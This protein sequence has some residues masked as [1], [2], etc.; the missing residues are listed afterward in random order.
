MKNMHTRTIVITHFDGDLPMFT[1]D[2]A[3]QEWL[4]MVGRLA[5]YNMRT[6]RQEDTVG[7]VQIMTRGENEM[8]AVYYPPEAARN[9][10]EEGYTDYEKPQPERELREFVDKTTGRVGMPGRPF[11]MGAILHRGEWGFHS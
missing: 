8:T 9:N 6:D 2:K 10:T 1:T 4:A 5:T 11:V 7:L 3:A